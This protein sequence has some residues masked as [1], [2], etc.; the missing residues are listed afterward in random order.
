MANVP[1]TSHKLTSEDYDLYRLMSDIHRLQRLLVKR[2]PKNMI[3]EWRNYFQ[4]WLAR[5]TLPSMYIY[6]L[7]GNFLS[8]Q[9]PYVDHL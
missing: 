4:D 3:R 6:H 9:E 2:C 7:D 8:R 1:L 5:K